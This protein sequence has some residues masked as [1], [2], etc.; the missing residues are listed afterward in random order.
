MGLCE[1][2]WGCFCLNWAAPVVSTVGLAELDGVE[3]ASG[4]SLLAVD[5]KTKITQ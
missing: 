1:G 4:L 5:K 2:G 3:G